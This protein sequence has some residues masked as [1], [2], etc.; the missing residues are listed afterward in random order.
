MTR[1]RKVLRFVAVVA[2]FSTAGG[3]GWP[4]DDIEAIIGGLPCC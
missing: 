4:M 2:A 3:A 1:V